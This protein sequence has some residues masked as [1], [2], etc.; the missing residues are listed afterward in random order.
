MNGSANRISGDR[1]CLAAL[2]AL[3]SRRSV[4]LGYHGIDNASRGEDPWRL[5]VSPTVFEALL[6]LMLRAGFRFVTVAALAGN[7]DG[8]APRS[9]VAAVSFDDGMRNNHS[10]ALPIL[11]RLAIPATVYVAVDLIGGHSP[12]VKG[13]GGEMLSEDEIRD[14]AGAG[15]E[16]GAHTM[17]HPDLA[18]LS[19]EECRR[20]IEDSRVALERIAAVEVE[21]F[22]YPFG[23]Y[24]LAAL[25]ATRDIGFKAAVTTGTGDGT[26]F[27]LTRAMVSSGDPSVVLMLKLTDHYEPLLRFPPLRAARQASKQLRRS[28]MKQ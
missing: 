5:Q 18:T 27:E 11:D 1:I 25:Q 13:N 10:I 21:T 24:G 3:A 14:L 9:G 2:S 17:T 19:Y 4:I 23:R 28:L 7:L 22:A 16:I 12:W 8:R 15:W 26:R 6:E 20:E